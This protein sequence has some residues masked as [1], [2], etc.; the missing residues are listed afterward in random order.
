MGKN[1]ALSLGA[2]EAQ[3]EWFLF[4]D[5]DAVHLAGSTRDGAGDCGGN[6]RGAG[7]VFS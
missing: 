3:G 7:F 5:A 4:T 6:W 2:A 1:Y